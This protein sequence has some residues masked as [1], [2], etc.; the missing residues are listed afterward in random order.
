MS[1]SSP[2]EQICLSESPAVPSR[3]IG[4][5]WQSAISDVRWPPG[6]RDFA[7]YPESGKGR[8]KGNGRSGGVR[9]S[10]KWGGSRS[11]AGADTDMSDADG[12]TNLTSWRGG[13]THLASR[14][15]GADGAIAISRPSM[16]V[17]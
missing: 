12:W 4:S 13:S 6:G 15:R 5:A 7:I 14:R 3:L 9:G 8:G 16:S 1:D 17:G 10:E 11:R 2:E